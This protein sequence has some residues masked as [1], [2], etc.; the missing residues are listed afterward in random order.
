[1]NITVD[2]QVNRFRALSAI[3]KRSSSWT[4]RST[5]VNF[6]IAYAINGTLTTKESAHRARHR[7]FVNSVAA[8]VMPAVGVAGEVS[9]DLSSLATSVSDQRQRHPRE[10]GLQSLCR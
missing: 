5:A 8:K 6:M 2:A 4:S 1:M 3:L 10:K 9:T 7:M